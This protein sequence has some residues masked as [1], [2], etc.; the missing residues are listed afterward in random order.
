M[1]FERAGHAT[2]LFTTAYPPILIGRCAKLWAY[3]TIGSKSGQM[4]DSGL[5]H[6]PDDADERERLRAHGDFWRY[7]DDL[8]DTASG[9]LSGT[10][11]FT[12]YRFIP[13]GQESS[14]PISYSGCRAKYRHQFT[15]GRLWK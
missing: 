12:V 7:L 14:R 3:M 4:C 2:V 8:L 11:R 1:P 5:I 10:D 6:F 13:D 9:A 15:G